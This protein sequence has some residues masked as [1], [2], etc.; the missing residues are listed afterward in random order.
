M[1]KRLKSIRRGIEYQDLVAA[2]AALEMVTAH[3]SPPIWI[4]LENRRGGTFDDVVVAYPGRV[5][6][7]Q[8]KWAENPGSEPLTIDSLATGDSRTKPLI[9]AFAGSHVK[10]TAQGS[11]FQLELITNRALD[12]EFQRFVSGTNS[13]IKPKLSAHQRTR[14]DS[15]WRA[16]TALDAEQFG[17]F[18]GTLSFLVNSPDISRLERA[19]QQ[20]LRLLHCRPD[21]FERLMRAI[22]D[23]AKDDAKEHITRDDVE[24]IL[25]PVT[26]TPS[27]EFHLPADRVDRPEAKDEI[28]RRVDQLSCGYLVV[29]G[30]P[31][32][33]KS[34]LLN[35]LYDREP[36]TQANDLIIYNCFTGTSD[37]FLR[38]RATAGNFARV[39]ARSLYDLYPDFGPLFDPGPNAIEEIL[40]RV[41]TCERTKKLVVVVDGI[42]Y[43][44]RFASPN[45]QNLFD[46]LPPRLPD[47][48]VV[49]VSAQ[50]AEQLP[51]HIR[52]TV[53]PTAVQIQSMDAVQ[54]KGVLARHGIWDKAALRPHE[55]DDIVRDVLH[56]TGGHALHVSYVAR[57]LAAAL[58]NGTSLSSILHDMPPSGGDIER[59]YQTLFTRPNPTLAR[60]ALAVMAQSPCELT[61]AEVAALLTP[62]A[63]ARSVED[64]IQEAAH[65][66][67]KTGSVYHF[68]HDSLRAFA[69][70][71]LPHDQFPVHRQIR[72]LSNLPSDPRTGEHL[73]HLFAEHDPSATFLDQI[74]CEWLA[75]Q[76]A[77]GANTA[78][79]WEGLE[80]LAVAE[81]ARHDWGR[82]AHW[83]SI[84]SCLEKAEFEGELHEATIVSAWLA[85]GDRGLVERY[86]FVASQFLSSVYPGPDLIDLLK[87]SGHVDLAERLATQWLSRSTPD[88]HTIGPNPEFEHYIRHLARRSAPEEITALV[89]RQC[90]KAIELKQDLGIS[91]AEREI[92]RFAKLCAYDSL[93]AGDFDRV[94]AWLS[95]DPSPF[96]DQTLA[97][98][99][100][101][102]HL[103]RGDLGGHKKDA[104]AAL[105][106]IDD[107]ELLADI[108][109][110]GL[111][112]QEIRSALRRLPL[113]LLV[114]SEVQ[115]FALSH[116]GYIRDLYCDVRLC[117]DLAIE[118]RLRKIESAIHVQPNRI[119]HAFNS[120][121]GTLARR[122]A[123]SPSDWKAGIDQLARTLPDAHSHWDFDEINAAQFYVRSVGT[124]LRPA[125]EAANAAV[126]VSEFDTFVEE[127]LIP[128][129]RKARIGYESGPLSICDL[130]Q[131]KSECRTTVLCLLHEVEASIDQSDKFK[132]GDLIELSAR[133]ARAGDLEAARQTL[134]SGIRAA[135]TY[136]YH[137]DTTINEFILAFEA[138][139]PHLGERKAEVV[140]FIA[141]VLCFLDRLT[142]ARM[143]SDAPA[144]FIAIICKVDIPTA[145]Q[146]A[147][148]LQQ[149]CRQLR[150]PLAPALRDHGLDVEAIRRA[151][152]LEA[153]TLDIGKLK[154][155]QDA[156]AY[157]VVGNHKLPTTK[158]QFQASVHE[159]I[160]SS[161]YATGLHHLRPIVESLVAQGQ[162]SQALAVFSEFQHALHQLVAVY[163]PFASASTG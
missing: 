117:H 109:A 111:F 37:A 160:E 39:L 104:R 140:Q 26:A 6:W 75:R 134:V 137:K 4:A 45:G 133:F 53:G 64:A 72:F 27:N 136:G 103:A 147:M 153:P 145:A 29:L 100:L 66:F 34:T 3:E 105:S 14:L 35:T 124:L 9:Q 57:Q 10:I 63:D 46:H 28:A 86:S 139:A 15:T 162:I 18:L 146:V 130:L 74:D 122:L 24:A 77:A 102:F 56:I 48:V 2:E 82:M 17:S 94:W 16:L 155:G 36:V 119:A 132:S 58:A 73:L 144:H 158:A 149:S 40:A 30:S 96:G 38:T 8:V 62:S 97:D 141:S 95:L 7:K 123:A 13:R 91:N 42:D 11:E 120:A 159:L 12:S 90:D 52:D 55:M 41:T 110:A 150:S 126:E 127:G 78:L 93:S 54:V 143:I 107:V 101:R 68:S 33:G 148:A 99:W 22:A 89:G 76:I 71:H 31:G 50:V 43:A 32:A 44:R 116:S 125:F 163:P 83:L 112:P 154:E 114:A 67:E 59:Y 5:V 85:M 1:A 152:T 79:L 69:L 47:N 161:R 92:E 98:L 61:A 19:I 20:Q 138:V 84:K 49:I 106:R 87:E 156:R 65:L 60:H 23:W 151:L 128:A 51:A 21:A 115:W 80:R 129:L 88:S 131:R 135:F 25:N 121:I 142:D 70:A 157:F 113:P 118:D 81:C 108:H